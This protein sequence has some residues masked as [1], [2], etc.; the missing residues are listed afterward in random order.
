MTD[1]DFQPDEEPK[2]RK[3]KPAKKGQ[4]T[5]AIIIASIAIGVIGISTVAL[6]TGKVSG[7]VWKKD[8]ADSACAGKK[9]KE[10][11]A[12]FGKPD[13]TVSD[14]SNIEI[15]THYIYKNR[16]LN[17]HTGRTGT[18]A[19]QFYFGQAEGVVDPDGY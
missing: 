12:V 18:L 16:L 2:P 8:E 6:A 4:S 3:E 5:L 14:P 17:P 1:F 9:Y 15:V 10:V 19:I 11:I 7:K 13:R